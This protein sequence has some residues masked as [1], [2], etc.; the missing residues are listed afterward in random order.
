V[1]TESFSEGL[2]AANGPTWRAMAAHPFVRGVADGSLPEDPWRAWVQQDR[3]FVLEE[4]RV[5]GA[6]RAQGP[7]PAL[8]R[9]CEQLDA[10]LV[11]EAAAFAAEA[12][13]LGFPA[14]TEAWPI[15][16]GYTSY[17][18]GAARDG[19]LEGLTALFGVERAYLDTWTAVRDSSRPDSP[20]HAWIQNWTG[21]EFRAFVGELGRLLDELAGAPP[22][23]LAAR[24]RSR[25]DRVARFELAFWEMA[26]KGWNWPL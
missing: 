14:D 8:E 22:P 25:F 9:L 10:A 23:A 19:V 7:P 20:Y 24:L 15:C 16:L 1:T 2:V 3:I 4:R 21:D 6:L 17:L 11:H 5:A 18:L 26:W 13:R 12:E